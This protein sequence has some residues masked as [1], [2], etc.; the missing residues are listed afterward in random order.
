MTDTKQSAAEV[1]EEIAAGRSRIAETAE[2]LQRKVS[3]GSL[4]DEILGATGRHGGAFARKLGGTIRDNP[5]PATLLGV[6][7]IWLMANGSNDEDRRRREKDEGVRPPAWPEP[8]DSPQFDEARARSQGSAEPTSSDRASQASP[9]HG[10]GVQNDDGDQD[11]S[12]KDKAV[13]AGQAAASSVSD[14]AGRV[15]AAV[16]GGA[17]QAKS[18]L[19]E[20]LD[21][22]GESVSQG[23]DRAKEALH[24]GAEAVGEQARRARHRAAEL[25]EEA[26]ERGGKV[27]NR[28][29]GSLERL[30]EEQPLVI[31]GLA[32]ALGAAIG[33]AVPN[34]RAENRL[35]GRKAEQMRQ[36][37]RGTAKAEGEKLRSVAKAAGEEAREVAKEVAGEA[38]D[39][40]KQ[41]ADELDRRVPAGKDLVDKAE[42]KVSSAAKRVGK[43]AEEE[44]E[45]VK[46]AKGKA[47]PAIESTPKSA[48][49]PA[50]KPAGKA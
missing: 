49:K 26:R 50:T 42:A 24:E 29:R 3:V 40:A 6:G 31:G 11:P 41:A 39:A 45:R 48:T 25:G 5:I 12:L 35:M 8:S 14:K 47:K 1:E 28:A 21:Q 44:A 27:A 20:G 7:L 18:T 10:G 23:A 32:L 19:S 9:G 16:S 38:R 33:G 15:K 2:A 30:I 34:S 37:I 17:D 13:A 43:A 22:A 4:V 46:L 36:D